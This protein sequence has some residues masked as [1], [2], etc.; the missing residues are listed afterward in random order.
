MNDNDNVA[1]AQILQKE[2]LQDKYVLYNT[3]G[4]SIVMQVIPE[5]V[6]IFFE[7]KEQAVN[8]MKRNYKYVA[9]GDYAIIKVKDVLV[10]NETI[11]YT[12]QD[13]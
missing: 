9:R 10:L 1:L 11:K 7:E 12:K 8:F 13:D 5:V 2:G 4:H 3:Y 6:P